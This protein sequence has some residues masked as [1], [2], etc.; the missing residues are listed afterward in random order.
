MTGARL[1]NSVHE[2]LAERRKN[3]GLMPSLYIVVIRL[4]HSSVGSSSV[5][6][7]MPVLSKCMAAG[8]R[9]KHVQLWPCI[10]LKHDLA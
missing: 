3:A 6:V 2:A 1:T 5:L 8:C 4:T 10:L 7:P 9:L